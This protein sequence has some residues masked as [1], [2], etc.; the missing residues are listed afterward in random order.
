M[1]TL[2][3]TLKSVPLQAI[4]YK[5]AIFI[6][7]NIDN[8]IERHGYGEVE[9]N[10]GISNST[11]FSFIFEG[12]ESYVDLTKSYAEFEIEIVKEKENDPAE[13]DWYSF[14]VIN[15]LA[16]GL[17]EDIEVI[18]LFILSKYF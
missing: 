6:N 2:N 8:T 1:P 13:I 3:E 18:L 14:G 7:A 17:F 12:V 9:H 15:N 11:Q 16:H 5:E 10:G 4:P